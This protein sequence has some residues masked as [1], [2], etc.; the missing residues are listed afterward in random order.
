VLL[1]D[2]AGLGVERGH[3]LADEKTGPFIET[4]NRVSGIA[5]QRIEPE[6]LLHG[7]YEVRVD[8]AQAPRFL[9]MRLERVFLSILPA[10]L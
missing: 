5:G 10:W 2:L 4:H 6:H 3:L 1:G 8:L 7:R 9:E